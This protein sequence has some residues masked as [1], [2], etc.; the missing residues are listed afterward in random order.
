M[1]IKINF[2]L[3]SVKSVALFHRAKVSYTVDLME[4]KQP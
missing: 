3:T 4:K 2:M 1:S